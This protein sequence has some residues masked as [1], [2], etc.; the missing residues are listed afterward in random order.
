MNALLFNAPAD[1]TSLSEY[2]AVHQADHF[3]ITRQLFQKL[4][5]ATIHQPPLDPIPMFD[6]LGWLM[7]H[8]LL[9]NELNGYLGTPGFDLTSV[10]FRDR[11]QFLIW[12]RY[13][14]LEH[15]AMT[16]ALANIPAQQVSG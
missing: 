9:H 10:D 12:S 14:A 5:I 3:E 8:Q 4:G 13:N 15:Y 11:T 6:L 1:E 2:S 16:E 7:N